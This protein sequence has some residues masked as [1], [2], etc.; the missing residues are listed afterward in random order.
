M[1]N[2]K[3]LY[4]AETFTLL[5]AKNYEYWFK[6]LQVIEDYIADIFWDMV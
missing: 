1:G 2:C 4:E 5:H 6:F 3:I